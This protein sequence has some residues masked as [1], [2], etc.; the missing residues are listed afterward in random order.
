MAEVVEKDLRDRNPSNDMSLR[1]EE[2]VLHLRL[3]SVI[4][5]INLVDSEFKAVE[6]FDNLAA[7]NL[8]VNDSRGGGF[9]CMSCKIHPCIF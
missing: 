6:I 5:Q 3:A 2:D 9:T 4:V 8:G 7:P 1:G